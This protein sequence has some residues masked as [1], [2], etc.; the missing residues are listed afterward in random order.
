MVNKALLTSLTDEWE[1]PQ[2]LFDKF[3]SE[4]HFTLDVCANAQNHKCAR[5]YNKADDGLKMPW[6]GLFG[7]ILPMAEKSANGWKNAQITMDW[8]SCYCQPEP[9]QDG[10]TSSYTTKQRCA[11]SKDGSSLVGARTQLH[12]QAWS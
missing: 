4:F 6:G 9:T 5:Y 7:A 12:S 1:T 11:L 10:S 8:R 3:D 2:D